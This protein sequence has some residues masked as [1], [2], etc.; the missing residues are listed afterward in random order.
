[1]KRRKTIEEFKSE[2]FLINK[3]ISVVG[4]Y[5]NAHTPIKCICLIHNNMFEKSPYSLLKGC[6]CPI[7]SNRKVIK[8]S[9]DVGT[10]HPHILKYLVNIEDAYRL[11]INSREKV[12]VKCPHCGEEKDSVV[13]NLN[14]YGVSC[15]K[16][17][18]KI[19]YPNKFVRNV[20]EQLGIKQ[21]NEVVFDWCDKDK[22]RIYDIYLPDFNTII[23]VHGKFHYEECNFMSNEFKSVKE[24]DLYKKEIAL[25]NGIKNYIEIDCSESTLN[26]IKDSI[27]KSLLNDMF[28]LDK[29]NWEMCHESALNNITKEVCDAYNSGTKHTL[30]LSKKFNMS[31]NAIVRHLKK[32][33]LIGWCDYDSR[34][35]LKNNGTKNSKKGLSKKIY[36]VEYDMQ[37]NSLSDCCRY[38]YETYG[39]NATQSGISSIKKGKNKTHCG[40]HFEYI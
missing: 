22:R 29:I 25:N 11:H 39:I 6:T 1:M 10:T 31:R 16:C 26:Y 19:S 38:L 20:F 7:C 12:K 2:L 15:P 3:N 30:E 8:G 5:I 18:D 27:I 9:N 21:E 28:C 14:K 36:C 17:G 40:L 4:N 35:A 33:Q 32:G 24:N 23:E 13:S 37:F 34:E